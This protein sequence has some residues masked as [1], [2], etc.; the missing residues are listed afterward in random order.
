MCNIVHTCIKKYT[1]A[2]QQAV[3]IVQ[4]VYSIFWLTIQISQKIQRYLHDTSA[5]G[6]LPQYVLVAVR[7]DM[8]AAAA[9]TVFNHGYSD[10]TIRLCT[11][12]WK[13]DSWFDS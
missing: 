7:R 2:V 3:S 5:I 9:M 4:L 12:R 8:P 13:F 6:L 10:L 11:R 1:V